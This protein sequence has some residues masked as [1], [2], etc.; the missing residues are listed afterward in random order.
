MPLTSPRRLSNQHID[1]PLGSHPRV[2]LFE[3]RYH[4]TPHTVIR[5]FIFIS[6]LSKL[7][8]YFSLAAI[9]ILSLQHFKFRLEIVFLATSV[10]IYPK[11]FLASWPSVDITRKDRRIC[12]STPLFLSLS[13]GLFF[14]DFPQCLSSAFPISVPS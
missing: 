2:N 11:K 3:M 6:A 8:V 10:L 7:S 9:C 5:S 4:V 12:T 14:L 1:S 13:F